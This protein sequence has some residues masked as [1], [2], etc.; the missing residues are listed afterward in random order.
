MEILSL[1]IQVDKCAYCIKMTRVR[2][3]G[4][5][6]ERWKGVMQERDPEVYLLFC[7]H[8]M[9][10]LLGVV[11]LTDVYSAVDLCG[12]GG[13]EKESVEKL[14]KGVLENDG[15]GEKVMAVDEII[16]KMVE[17]RSVVLVE[18][19]SGSM[20]RKLEGAANLLRHLKAHQARNGS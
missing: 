15:D 19:S 17:E 6:M 5:P 9:M 12:A 18:E 16:V 13:E 8:D 2:P 11:A 14:V 4:D 3:E 20:A 7:T 1:G 10:L